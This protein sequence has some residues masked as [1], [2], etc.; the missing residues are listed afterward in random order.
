MTESPN[1]DQFRPYLQTLARIQLAQ[2]VRSR[3]DASDIVQQTMLQAHQAWG[4]FRGASKQEMAAWLRQ[5]LARN[6]AHALRDH[7][8]GKRDVRRELSL[9]DSLERSSARMV[10][11]LSAG[12]VGPAQRVEQAERLLKLADALEQ[13]IPDQRTAVELHY[14][15]ELSVSDVAERM[16]RTVAAIGGL[17]HR[18][19]RSLRGILAGPENAK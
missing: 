6:L 12:D 9:Q 15:Q 4:S 10:D 17:L 11:L 14:L 19:L 7:Q 3:L 5:I 18:G 1:L 16:G 8:R 13:M 2:A